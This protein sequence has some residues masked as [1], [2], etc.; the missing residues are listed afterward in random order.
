METKRT[1]EA[2]FT[3]TLTDEQ[4]E[5]LAALVDDELTYLEGEGEDER[6]DLQ[7]MC[8]AIHRLL[9]GEEAPALE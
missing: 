4:A 2:I 3:I 7:E 6:P 5:F 8:H 1:G 9:R